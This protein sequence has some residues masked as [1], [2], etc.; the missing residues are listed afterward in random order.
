MTKWIAALF[1]VAVVYVGWHLYL[2]WDQVQQEQDIAQ[3]QASAVVTPDQLPGLPSELEQSLQTAQ[4][5]GA[6]TLGNWLK[7]YGR[8]IKDPRK[9]WI[10]LDYCV[11]LSVENP[12][13]A[14]RIFAQVKART[15]SSSPVYP[16]IRKLEKTY[17]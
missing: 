12:A 3:K 14:K 17:E 2:Y 11:A 10:E 7:L 16:R 13:E 15:S 8:R 1:V 6:A 9:A 5:R 4:Q